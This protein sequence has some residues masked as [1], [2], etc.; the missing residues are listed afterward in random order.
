MSFVV[1]IAKNF[2]DNYEDI[3]HI[4]MVWGKEGTMYVCV[5]S[6]PEA[7]ATTIEMSVHHQP[8]LSW[9]QS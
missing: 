2:W 5:S 7:I 6:S 4:A 8:L 9:H 3:D 1:K